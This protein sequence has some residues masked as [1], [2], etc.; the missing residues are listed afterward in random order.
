MAN[1]VNVSVG[2][3]GV[4]VKVASGQG[5]PVKVTGADGS[6]HISPGSTVIIGK[7]PY[8]NDETGTWMVYNDKEHTYVD[9]GVVA[10]SPIQSLSEEFI[11]DENGELQIYMVSAEKIDG[12]TDLIGDPIRGVSADGLPLPVIDNIVN[13]PLAD[14][15]IAG[16]VRSSS[17]EN[18]VAVAQDGKMYVNSLNVNRLMQTAGEKFT[19]N[20]GNSAD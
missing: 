6:V 16:L 11:I 2:G 10:E 19:L 7:S 17:G 12:L 15:L 18:S 5:V 4:S 9:S 3:Q 20:A 1:L 8:I 14:D 13:V